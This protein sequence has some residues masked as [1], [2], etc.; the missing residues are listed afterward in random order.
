MRFGHWSQR[1][2]G[3]IYD[4]A[5]AACPGLGEI[6]FRILEV[7]LERRCE[8]RPLDGAEQLSPGNAQPPDAA[9]VDALQHLG[10]RGVDLG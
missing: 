4:V 7:L 9:A 6:A 10:D 2:N 8:R 3:E 1:L 5:S